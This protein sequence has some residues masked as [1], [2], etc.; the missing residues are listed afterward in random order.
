MESEI[1]VVTYI[2][3]NACGKKTPKDM[4]IWRER[5]LSERNINKCVKTTS[6]KVDTQ[7]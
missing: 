1:A 3:S 4:C 6:L 5:F 2:K 7:S